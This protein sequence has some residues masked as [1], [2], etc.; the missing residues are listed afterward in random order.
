LR[1]HTSN[2]KTK[3]NYEVLVQVRPLRSGD[4]TR[5]NCVR[6]TSKLLNQPINVTCKSKNIAAN[7]REREN[8]RKKEREKKP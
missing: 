7:E 3:K 8:E 2:V 6:Q 1:F 4:L 5:E